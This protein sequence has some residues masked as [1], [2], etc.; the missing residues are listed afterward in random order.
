MIVPSENTIART[1]AH[2]KGQQARS[3]KG[4]F[5]PYGTFSGSVLRRQI[6]LAFN[7]LN[8]AVALTFDYRFRLQKDGNRGEFSTIR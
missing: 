8:V 5:S 2:E 3:K 4:H 7:D 6:L 1:P